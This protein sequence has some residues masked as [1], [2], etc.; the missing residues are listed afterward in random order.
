VRPLVSTA[1]GACSTCESGR[2][3]KPV[4]LIKIRPRAD[5]AE[6][7]IGLCHGCAGQVAAELIR[8]VTVPQ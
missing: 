2:D 4:H 6:N 8:I 5:I 1:M 3:G 7:W